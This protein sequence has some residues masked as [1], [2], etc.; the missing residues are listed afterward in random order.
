MSQECNI[1]GPSQYERPNFEVNRLI[2]SLLSAVLILL[3]TSGCRTNDYHSQLIAI[4]SLLVNSPALALDSLSAIDPSCL[5][6][7]ERAYF[8]LLSTIAMHKNRVLIKNDSLISAVNAWYSLHD[9]ASHNAAR[10]YFY[11][12]LVLD[13]TAPQEDT[14]ALFCYKMSQRLLEG[15]VQ[16]GRLSA[17]LYAYLGKRYSRENAMDQAISCF[18]KAVGYEKENGNTVNLIL[19]YC[20]LINSLIKADSLSLAREHYSEFNEILH[21]SSSIELENVNNTKAIYYTY[22][23][24][25]PDSALMYCRK[26]RPAPGDLS[27]KEQM[28]SR[29]F[30]TYNMPDSALFYQKA[31]FLHRR[32]S[33]SLSVHVMY[34]G[35]SDLY[36]LKGEKDSSLFYSD[37]AYE[38]LLGTLDSRNEK[39]LTEL[40]LRYDKTL[41]ER[42]LEHVVKERNIAL[43][44]LILFFIALVLSSFLFYFHRKNIELSER[45]NLRS[46][47]ADALVKSVAKSY[48]GINNRL[49]VIHNLPDDKRQDEIGRLIVDTKSSLTSNLGKAIDGYYSELPPA[50]QTVVD[51]LNGTQ[52]KSVFVLTELGCSNREIEQIDQFIF[53]LDAMEKEGI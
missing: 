33:D 50:V 30:R 10:A 23:D 52:Q 4:D 47:I 45:L 43:W 2:F 19:D 25:H 11:H 8:G 17:L 22:C 15:S 24:I 9:K 21:H 13:K 29:V 49:T 7:Q 14:L 31:A 6:K 20:L 16:D 26:W 28:L 48:S 32:P 38:S 34:R 36:G 51:L 5:S 46:R 42:E 12:G 41:K 44:L 3:M 39:R 53:K 27:A 1:Q 37:L 35:I 40:S 18:S